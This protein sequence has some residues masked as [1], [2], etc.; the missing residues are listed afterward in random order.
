MTVLKGIAAWLALTFLVGGVLGLLT[1]WPIGL[2]AFVLAAVFAWRVFNEWDNRQ[3]EWG[4][5]NVRRIDELEARYAREDEEAERQEEEANR[6]LPN[7]KVERANVPYL[8]AILGTF[9]TPGQVI[10]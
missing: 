3:S 10:D 2:L 8:G 4:R 6:R 7:A 5:Q 9:S 1:F